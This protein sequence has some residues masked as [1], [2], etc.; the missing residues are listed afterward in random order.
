MAKPKSQPRYRVGEVE[1]A[2]RENGG[3][4]TDAAKTLKCS[5]RTVHAYLN[6]YPHLKEVRDEMREVTSDLAFGGLYKALKERK[7]WAIKLACKMDALKERRAME[8]NVN[9]SGAV[10]LRHQPPDPEHLA[11][12][13][14]TLATAGVP[15]ASLLGGE[16]PRRVNGSGE[17]I[18]EGE[19]AA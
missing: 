18:E 8:L 3:I 4:L 6:R 1:A 19:A 14:D 17:H 2:L 11:E 9:L 16:A 10:D 13:I 7:P 15:L 5:R 12:M